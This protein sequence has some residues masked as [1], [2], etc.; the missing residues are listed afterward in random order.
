MHASVHA[1]VERTLTPADVRDRR[2]LEVGSLD[3]NGS[4]RSFVQSLEPS[5]YLGVDIAEGPGVDRVCPAEELIQTFGVCEWD[6][7]ISTECLE[8]VE[9]WRACIR[10]LKGVTRDLLLIT[11]R[12]LGFPYHPHPIDTWRYE[13]ADME[14]IFADFAI[15]ALEPDP[16]QPG[17]FLRARKV[18]K[19]QVDLD[20][21]E[22]F[23]W[24]G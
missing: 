22:L 9:D 18:D 14:A 3:V 23:R 10:N 20:V 5:E 8:H 16:E 17:V 13:L 4:V 1:F 6:C 21:I 12:S 2:V 7:V 15:E 11:T 24:D 19:P